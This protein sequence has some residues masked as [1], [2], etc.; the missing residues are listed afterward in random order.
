MITRVSSITLEV[1]DIE[2]SIGFFEE[3]IGLTVTERIGDR[4][5]LRARSVHH[6]LVLVASQSGAT[7]LHT[8]NFESDDVASDIARAVAAGAKDHGPIDHAGVDTAHLLEAPGEIG[9]LI[10]STLQTVDAAPALRLAQPAHFSHF[11][12]GTPDPASLIRFF[13]DLG[14]RNSDWIG[15]VEEPLIGWLHCPVDGA[16]HHGVA[17]LQSP[18]TRLHHIS[19][20]YDTTEQ[21]V[22]RVDNFV[23]DTHFLVWG[24][25]R[26][27]TGG[28]IFAYMNDVSGVMVELG[29]G[30]IRIGQDPRW[31]GPQVWPLDDPRGVDEWGS[32]VPDAW[33]A[34]RVDVSSPATLRIEA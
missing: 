25:G 33:M 14:M 12:I 30:M 28:S 21:I 15:S 17:V 9:L 26:H 27:G 31:N 2:S 3:H 32:S 23:D 34:Q 11:N 6:D 22:D 19:Y 18:D 24:M 20:E 29:T 7:S 10:H 1:P 4:A 13:V 16:L 5:Y 8:L